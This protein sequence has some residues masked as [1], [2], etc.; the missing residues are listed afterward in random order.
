M[1]KALNQSFEQ[2]SQ[3]IMDDKVPAPSPPC[4]DCSEVVGLVFSLNDGTTAR[5]ADRLA[6]I[7]SVDDAVTSDWFLDNPYLRP[8]RYEENFRNTYFM[9]F[10][11]EL[12]KEYSAEQLAEL[13]HF[14]ACEELN[15]VCIDDE[16][17]RDF[18]WATVAYLR[19]TMLNEAKV[20]TKDG[21]SGSLQLGDMNF[22]FS[23]ERN[24]IYY[25][26]FTSANW[27]SKTGIEDEWSNFSGRYDLARAVRSFKKEYAAAR[28]WVKTRTKILGAGQTALAVLTFIP[29]LAPVR[30][31]TTLGKTVR[32]TFVAL[33][34]ALSA[35]MLVDGS[36]KMISGEGLDV[37]EKIF[38]TLGELADPKDGAERGRQVFLAINI[39]M[40]TPAAW[41]GTKWFLRRFS[42]TRS[43]MAALDM[44]NAINADV[45][46]WVKNAKQG[47]AVS[48]HT[49][50]TKVRGPSDPADIRITVIDRPSMDTNRWQ[51]MVY[52]DGGKAHFNYMSR[53]LRPLE[54]ALVQRIHNAGGSIRVVGRVGSEVGKVGE[55]VFARFMMSQFGVP[56]DNI[57]GYRAA[58][59]GL[60]NKS[61]HGIDVLIKVPP[62]PSM[63][64][65]VPETDV[66]RNAIEG[67]KG[68]TP[69]RVVTF[70]PD[71]LLVI[72]VKTT[73]GGVETPRLISST[74]AKGGAEDLERILGLINK[75]RKG[76]RPALMS[77]ADPD[78]EAK[79]RA[80][81]RAIDS[82]RIEFMHAQV[83][84]KQNGR[85]NGAVGNGS[86]I[87]MG[88]WE[89]LR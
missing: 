83:F 7:P 13:S 6:G 49:K 55:E 35:N 62:P 63:T 33:D 66:A 54:D 32:Y 18:S 48:I 81:E 5:E 59:M 87:Q 76:W 86:G 47:E 4:K 71:T 14:I 16:M 29:V 75:E 44:R 39:A 20:Q 45:A 22:W 27:V 28:D 46:D 80:I 21:K 69:T 42:P 11:K 19:R 60:T 30:A 88:A 8:E 64:I 89:N 10:L 52:V 61:G 67:T 73:L 2:L 40:L 84:L 34:T 53:T 15:F 74:Q 57:L 38:E 43:T 36:N 1:S 70:E 72:E 78:Y 37:G 68:T 31:V 25:A 85:V 65:R 82:G 41:G 12:E 50:L 17:E 79:L 77:E 56:A 23:F 26:T 3:D 51:H 9:R 24:A 58:R